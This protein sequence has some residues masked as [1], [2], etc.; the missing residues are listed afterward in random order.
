MSGRLFIDIACK[1]QCRNGSAPCDDTFLQRRY[2]DD[3]RMVVVLTDTT[4][5]G[6]GAE[7]FV[8]I[9]RRGG[10][11][12]I[13]ECDHRQALVLRGGELLSVERDC[14][15]ANETAERRQ[16][17]CTS[18]V[19]VEAGDRI[20]LLTEGVLRSGKGGDRF[21]FGWGRDGVVAFV[22]ALIVENPVMTSASLASALV[23][24]AAAND[25]GNPA[26]DLAVVAIH[27]RPTRSML[28]S[29]GVEPLGK[30]EASLFDGEAIVL[31]DLSDLGRV[32]AMLSDR[33]EF[34]FDR[35][36]AAE[37]CR[38]LVG[39]DRVM[40]RAGIHGAARSEKSPFGAEIR[41]DQ[42]IRIATLLERQYG[43]VVD[44]SFV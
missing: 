7:T 33:R 27:L 44:I 3:D 30:G 29:S 8:E 14:Q 36:P 34:L 19:T 15:V 23:G 10:Q 1:Q 20:V 39:C 41:C 12:T 13:V 17:L 28:F 43:K 9:D 22:Q 5:G 18:W 38:K 4:T 31:D 11:A 32:C 26:D 21:P 35:S 40:I 24:R 25:S 2:V 6:D 16:M 37:I 42:L